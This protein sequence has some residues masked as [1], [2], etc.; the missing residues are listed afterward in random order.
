MGKKV[1]MPASHAHIPYGMESD[2]DSVEL[3][4]GVGVTAGSCRATT[5]ASQEERAES[6]S[7]L[8]NQE[9]A[10]DSEVPECSVALEFAES[11]LS[12]L[13][14]AAASE[15]NGS[16]VALKTKQVMAVASMGK[17]E[18]SEGNVHKVTETVIQYDTIINALKELRCLEHKQNRLNRDI[19]ELIKELKL[20]RREESLYG[21]ILTVI[22]P[23][24]ELYGNRQR[25]KEM[26]EGKMTAER[27]L[28]V[29]ELLKETEGSKLLLNVAVLQT[30]HRVHV[31]DAMQ[32]SEGMGKNGVHSAGE[33]NVQGGSVRVGG[34]AGGNVWEERRF[35]ACE[36]NDD[37]DDQIN[38]RINVV[39]NKW[40]N[41]REDFPGHRFVVR[42]IIKQLLDF[43]PQDIY[44]LL[45]VTDTEFDEFWRRYNQ[46][47]EAN[48]WE[49]FRVGAHWAILG[50]LVTCHP[51]F[52][53]EDF[54]KRIGACA[55]A[56]SIFHFSQRKK[57]GRRSGRLVTQILFSFVCFYMDPP[58]LCYK[59]GSNRIYAMKCNLQKCALLRQGGRAEGVRETT[60][61]HQT[62]VRG[63]KREK[64]GRKSD[65]GRN[66][67]NKKTKVL[68][69]HEKG[70][71]GM[72]G[73]CWASNQRRKKKSK[74]EEA[75]ES[76][77]AD[78][79]S[80]EEE[81]GMV[82]NEAGVRIQVKRSSGKSY[83][84]FMT[85]TRML[86]LVYG[87]EGNGVERETLYIIVMV[88]KY[89]LWHMRFKWT[90]GQTKD[91][92]EHVS[93]V[94]VNELLFIKTME[95]EKSVGNMMLCRNVH[96]PF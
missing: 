92:T 85:I 62:E 94:I 25:F 28:Q 27:L 32:V 59:R 91:P 1:I 45:R 35:F 31:V 13:E 44:A 38:K 21:N 55:L 46:S 84:H 56:Q 42:N 17:A 70:E 41:E 96:I 40:V 75:S 54:R 16:C 47:K 34:A 72:I 30:L 65:M 3:E 48:E 57:E 83:M 43:T 10:T 77:E 79:E 2:S 24:K 87:W 18:V 15:E 78:W 9:M 22:E 89:Y 69:S 76:Q 73:K 36:R 50:D 93:K 58:R 11:A 51:K 74:R 80:L 82:S 60:R 37:S 20:L 63:K 12:D 49:A 67:G 29:A 39:K 68:M 71:E 81:G 4:A 52:P 33:N 8:T 95:S 6:E 88:I 14:M 26:Q 64:D 66:E 19:D 5:E 90:L 61:G 86:Y 7:A 53:R 23:W